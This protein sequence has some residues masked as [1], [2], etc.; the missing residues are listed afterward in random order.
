ML[1]APIPLIIGMTDKE[2]QMI[3]SEGILENEMDQRIWIHLKTEQIENFA[4]GK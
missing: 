4:E 1:E 2:Y 3:L